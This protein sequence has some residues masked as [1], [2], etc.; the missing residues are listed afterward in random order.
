MVDDILPIDAILPDVV[1]MLV[2]AGRAVLQAPPGAGK[3]TRVPLALL[4]SGHIQGRI[5]MLEPR[6]LAARASATRMAESLGEAP[7]GQ[8]GYRMRGET[9]VSS[10]TRIEVVTEGILTRMLQSDPALEGV[11][12]VIFDEFH[13]RSLNA[14]L[15][16][17]LVLEARAALRPDLAVLV[18]SA[19]LDAAPVAALMEDA[20]ILTAQGR[21]YEVDTRYLPQPMA[22]GLRFEAGMAALIRQAL[23]ES[24]GD[25]LAF[26]PGEGEIRR[27]RVLLDGLGTEVQALYGAMP[28]A[29]QQA[30]LRPTAQRRVVLATAIAET[31]LTI[32]GIRVVVDGGLARRAR[33]DPDTGMSSLITE[34]ASRAEAEQRRGRAGRVAP[35]VCW[36]LWA[37]AE[38]GA[39]PGFAPPEIAR[40]DLAGLA[41]EMALWGG[42]AGLRFLTP[43]P[44]A[45][46]GA[47]RRLLHDLGALDEP[48]Q[49][50][51]PAQTREGA[52]EPPVGRITDHGRAMAALPLHPRLAHMGLVAGQS[53]APLAALLA[54]RDPLRDAPP[55][56][57]RRLACIAGKPEA[58]ADL[59]TLARIREE[60][61]RLHRVL[62]KARSR[63][64]AAQMVA[65]AY[66]DRI[67]LRRGGD[68]PAWTLSGGRGAQ[69][70]PGLPLSGARLIVAT[71][72]DGEGA[73]ARIRQAIALPEPEMRHLFARQIVQDTIC[74]WSRRDGRVMARRQDRFGALVLTDSPWPDVPPE[75]IATAALEGIKAEGLPWSQTARR[76]Q[77]RVE[78]AR[79]AGEDLPAMDDDILMN[80]AEAWLLPY[81]GGLRSRAD[82]RGVDLVAPLRARLGHAGATRL[83]ALYPAQFT[84]PLGR[85]IAIDYTADTP[86]IEARIQ[87]FFG[88]AVH[89]TVGPTRTALRIVLLSP[90]A[91]PVQ[92]TTDLPGFWRTSYGD[93][94]K[95]MRGRYPRHPWPENPAEAAPTTRTKPR[96]T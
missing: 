34:R 78:E 37:R 55:D 70:A 79:L 12:A 93:V 87:E 46:L 10:A 61:R 77:A 82:L 52:I 66:P 23:E 72:L 24:E 51:R 31:S 22:K 58:T 50:A 2:R 5:V 40:A 49:S 80:E 36:R 88:V 8:I 75:A 20:P 94:R 45:A 63:L 57:E 29:L 83:E 56:L 53:A 1:Q 27:L 54:E 65:L 38:E 96:G 95:D 13:E 35:G 43:P 25:V 16:L 4:Q 84:T 89:P 47:A 69:M 91:K 15:G 68:A 92:V 44:K 67:G 59:P 14:D 60:A 11:G 28:F 39:M 90:A 74:I 26:V 86:T 73:N 21:S 7:G 71:D 62:P 41:L 64:S 81:L 76:L 33:F 18:M 85:G 9:V 48:P 42:D 19:T 30:V 6:R 3:T 32:P 17:A